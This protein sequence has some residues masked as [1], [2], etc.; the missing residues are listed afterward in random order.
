MCY[1]RYMQHRL[2]NKDKEKLTATCAVCGP[3]TPMKINY[4]GYVMCRIKWRQD[5]AKINKGQAQRKVW[6]NE[7]K[8]YEQYYAEYMT[9]QQGLCGICKEEMK[10]PQLDHC[11][12]T[13]EVRGLL[14]KNCNLGLGN[15]RDNQEILLSAIKYLQ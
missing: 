3:N 10:N 5:Q 6:G 12:V 4:R 2:S 1:Y 7:D 13:N 9:S 15:F 11:H 14:C 8:T